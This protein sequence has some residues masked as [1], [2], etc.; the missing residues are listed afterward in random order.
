MKLAAPMDVSD[1]ACSIAAEVGQGQLR[2]KA[3][4]V[5][6]LRVKAGVP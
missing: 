3:L 2:V 1:F 6:A 4:R 5:K